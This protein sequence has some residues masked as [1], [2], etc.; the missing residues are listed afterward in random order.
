[1][2]AGARRSSLVK[3]HWLFEQVHLAIANEKDLQKRSD[4]LPEMRYFSIEGAICYVGFA[5]D[6]GP[7]DLGSTCQFCHLI[8]LEKKRA[9]QRPIA[10]LVPP[11]R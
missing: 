10:L 5:D 9:C 8:E 3:I 2:R 4:F 11:C 6:F 7:M 1:M